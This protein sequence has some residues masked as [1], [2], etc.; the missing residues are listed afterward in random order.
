[1]GVPI[2]A[3][4]RGNWSV[5]PRLAMQHHGLPL[6]IEPVGKRVST[7]DWNSGRT[8]HNNPLL[9][10][11]HVLMGTLASCFCVSEPSETFDQLTCFRWRLRQLHV[12]PPP[13][14]GREQ[15]TTPLISRQCFDQIRGFAGPVARLLAV[16]EPGVR[17]SASRNAFETV[18]GGAFES[19]NPL[20]PGWP[21][22]AFLLWV[23]RR[24]L[25]KRCPIPRPPHFN[26]RTDKVRHPTTWP[27]VTSQVVSPFKG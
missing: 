26:P 22:L 8:L 14:V 18:T 13:S 12:P 27:P 17:L 1:M 11:L 4:A 3:V 16:G 2:V 7:L 24:V 25:C 15:K 6:G 9:H 10:V 20:H 19:G 21:G 5:H 23:P